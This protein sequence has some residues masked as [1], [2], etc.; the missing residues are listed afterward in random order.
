[1]SR[2]FYWNV[3][4]IKQSGWKLCKL[5]NE[6]EGTSIVLRKNIFY[7]RMLLLKNKHDFSAKKNLY[8]SNAK[9]MKNIRKGIDSSRKGMLFF[10]PVWK[11]TIVFM[12]IFAHIQM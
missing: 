3:K 8:K 12:Q 7:K 1:M 4:K 10:F 6:G 9:L 5:N 2:K 11:E